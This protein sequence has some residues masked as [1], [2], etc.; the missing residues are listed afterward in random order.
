MSTS[1]NVTRTLSQVA[2]TSSLEQFNSTMIALRNGAGVMFMTEAFLKTVP[3]TFSVISRDKN[4][5]KSGLAS[6]NFFLPD[7]AK[8]VNLF[9]LLVFLFWKI[10]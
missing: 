4:E 10:H 7:M 8:F 2:F 3:Q 6:P 5:S 1:V 9:F